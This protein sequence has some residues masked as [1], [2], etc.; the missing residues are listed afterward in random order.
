MQTDSESNFSRQYSKFDKNTK[1]EHLEYYEEGLHFNK[2]QDNEKESDEI[3]TNKN[4]RNFFLIALVLVI[5]AGLTLYLLLKPDN[6]PI[7]PDPPS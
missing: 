4:K 5:I 3:K 2:S 7:A 1:N 6:V